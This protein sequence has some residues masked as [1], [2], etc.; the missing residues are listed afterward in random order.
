M[1]V[2]LFLVFAHHVRVWEGEKRRDEKR[3]IRHPGLVTVVV[4]GVRECQGARE[5]V[6]KYRKAR[7]PGRDSGGVGGA[8][9]GPRGAR[10]GSR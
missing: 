5:R 2:I 1:R 3:V 7:R 10:Y 9:R 6:A 8:G 4:V